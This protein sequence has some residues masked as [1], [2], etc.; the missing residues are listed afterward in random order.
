MF[1]DGHKSEFK[2]FWKVCLGIVEK[3]CLGIVEKVC[4]GMVVKCV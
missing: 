3:V 1:R 2:D 4:L